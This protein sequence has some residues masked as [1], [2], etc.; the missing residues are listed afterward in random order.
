MHKCLVFTPPASLYPLIVFASTV[1]ECNK[2]ARSTKNHRRPSLSPLFCSPLTRAD[3]RS[4]RME[5][6]FTELIERRT[7]EVKD[8]TAMVQ[9]RRR[10]RPTMRR[11][12]E[13]LCQAAIRAALRRSSVRSVRGKA[14]PR[15]GSGRKEEGNFQR[16]GRSELG[17]AIIH[18]RCWF[19]F[20]GCICSAS[21]R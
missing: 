17:R 14:S 8:A 15:R 19:Y 6:I 11:S 18:V 12:E 20:A 5:R 4:P 7:E 10:R 9:R 16:T 3:G 1:T 21:I 13:A 2:N